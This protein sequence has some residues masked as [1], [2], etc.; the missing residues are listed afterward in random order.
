MSGYGFGSLGRLIK[1]TVLPFQVAVCTAVFVNDSVL[2]V[3]SVNGSSMHPTLSPNY[4]KD[5]S[6]DY[7]V[8]KKWNATKNL[9]RGDI[10]LCHSLQSPDNLSI[11][12]VVAV[13]GDIVLLDPKRRPEKVANGRLNP[14]FRSWEKMYETG[15]GRKIVPPGHVW[16]EGDNWRSTH[17]S[18]AYGPIS[19]SLIIGKA[20]GVFMPF[21]QFG[22]RPWENYHVRTKVIPG[23]EPESDTRNN[24]AKW[25]D[26]R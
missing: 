21:G 1:Y 13:G 3:A 2:E 25:W 4:E 14:Y 23:V 8:W 20:H 18:N 5:G 12:R 9:K 22:S 6:R 17:D 19:K 11:K 26:A 7:V 16:V 10:V 24:A 15:H